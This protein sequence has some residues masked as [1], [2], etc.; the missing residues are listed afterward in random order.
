MS[1]DRNFQIE[2]KSV[3]LLPGD[4]IRLWP[5]GP[6]TTLDEVGPEVE[7][8]GSV[9]TVGGAAMLRN[10]SD[11][12]LTVRRPANGKPNGTGPRRVAPQAG[13]HLPQPPKFC[14]MPHGASVTASGPSVVT[15]NFTVQPT[16]ARLTLIVTAP[17]FCAFRS[18]SLATA[19]SGTGPSV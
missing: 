9:G 17:R 18:I 15:F 3:T 14:V 19:M 16:C 13:I 8:C 5:D 4:I 10:V 7:F 11:P 2:S 6:P 1:Y 12:T